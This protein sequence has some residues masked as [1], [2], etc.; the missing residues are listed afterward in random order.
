MDEKRYRRSKLG[1]VTVAAAAVMGCASASRPSP[2]LADARAV[3]QRAAA[4]HAQQLAPARLIHARQLLDRAERVHR[5]DARSTE[6]RHWAYLAAQ[7]ARL[8]MAY[9][10]LQAAR[11]QKQQARNDYMVVRERLFQELQQELDRTRA[12]LEQ[13]RGD[14]AQQEAAGEE[15]TG[16][17]DDLRARQRQLEERRADLEQRVIEQHVALEQER[18]A[19]KQAAE[20]A[21]AALQRLDEVAQVER[22]PRETTIILSGATLFRPGSS[23]LA[24]VARTK[25]DAVAEALRLQADDSAIV[26]EGHASATADRAASE[27]RSL[28]RAESVRRYLIERGVDP[29][30]VRAVGKGPEEPAESNATPAGR[31]ANRRVEIIVRPARRAAER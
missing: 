7:H 9:A 15:L 14:L 29:D 3:Y 24:P 21:H 28:A 13:V 5:E 26:V 27:Q 31:A 10:D 8:S 19:Q 16:Q 12:E 1:V 17:L 6:E 18:R 25:L 22:Q 23:E 2:Q 30:Q 20:R 11:T 4:S